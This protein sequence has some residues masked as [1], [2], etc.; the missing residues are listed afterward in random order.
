LAATRRSTSSSFDVGV[1]ERTPGLGMFTAGASEA[2]DEALFDDLRRQRLRYT[3][4][5]NVAQTMVTFVDW[6]PDLVT[7]K[8]DSGAC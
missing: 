6:D 5:D 2:A 8:R 7:S 1:M 4:D 3:D